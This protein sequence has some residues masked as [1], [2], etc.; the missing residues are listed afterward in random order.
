[1]SEVPHVVR[2]TCRH[3]W[4]GTKL[5]GSM[6][7]WGVA[8]CEAHVVGQHLRVVN[9]CL[10]CFALSLRAR[11]LSFSICQDAWNREKPFPPVESYL[12]LS[13]RAEKACRHTSQDSS[14]TVQRHHLP[15]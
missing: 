2:S 14:N 10:A 6:K 4:P 11:A 3:E 8:M 13:V 5:S 12:A 15:K 9:V 7:M 1:M